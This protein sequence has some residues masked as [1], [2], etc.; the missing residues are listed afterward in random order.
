MDADSPWIGSL[1]LWESE[2]MEA[3]KGKWE[4]LWS[5]RLELVTDWAH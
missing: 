4:L 1:C 5:L 2:E 3:N